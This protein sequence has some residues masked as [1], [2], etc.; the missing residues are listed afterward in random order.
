MTMSVGWVE[1]P[2]QGVN[3]L[4]AIPIWAERMPREFTPAQNAPFPLMSGNDSSVPRRENF[5]NTAAGQSAFE[6]AMRLYTWS[7]ETAAVDMRRITGGEIK[8]HMG[9]RD[10]VGDTPDSTSRGIPYYIEMINDLARALF[11]EINQ[12]HVQGWSDNPNGSETGIKFFRATGPDGNPIGRVIFVDA[13]G[14]DLPP[15]TTSANPLVASA[16][17]EVTPEELANVT[18]L[19]FD[20]SD[21]IMASEFNIAS[22]S[23]RIGRTDGTPIELQRGN[24]VNMNALYSIFGQ[25]GISVTVIGPNGLERTREIGT[26]DDYGTVIRFN[27]ANTLHTAHQNTRTSRA[28]TLS[29]NNQRTAIAGVSLDEEMV[30]LVRFQHAYNGAARIITAIDEALDRLIN[31]TGR[32]GI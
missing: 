1:N 9:V 30:G 26:F 23:E 19:N 28:L 12:Q 2:V 10:G 22:S 7:V 24:N 21:A 18:A 13:N 20:V 16:R 15:G 3:T 32:V 27:V 31:G 8:A 11:V 5:E 29:A 4:V 17:F 14:D 25:T 6:N